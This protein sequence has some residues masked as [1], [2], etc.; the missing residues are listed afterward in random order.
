MITHNLREEHDSYKRIMAQVR[1]KALED[2]EKAVREATMPMLADR[3]AFILSGPAGIVSAAVNA[4]RAL[5]QG[6]L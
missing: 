3:D 2:A 5:K 4:I 1:A 6:G